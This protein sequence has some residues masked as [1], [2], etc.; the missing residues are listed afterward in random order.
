MFWRLKKSFAT[1]TIFGGGWRDKRFKVIVEE[2][3]G[4]RPHYFFYK[5]VCLIPTG[6]KTGH[7][8]QQKVFVLRP[9]GAPR[10]AF[11]SAE[12]F[13]AGNVL[14]PIQERHA[15][16]CPKYQSTKLLFTKRFERRIQDSNVF[17]SFVLAKKLAIKLS[18]IYPAARGKNKYD[19]SIR[20]Y[21][22]LAQNFLHY[23]CDAN[24][25]A[26]LL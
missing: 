24:C 14:A 7:M 18:S 2:P 17:R 22:H 13:S 20:K 26:C 3:A 5:D 21:Q 15:A 16:K 25:L 6:H 23:F 19:C 10:H 9:D 11:N 12:T 8:N 1:A 4:F